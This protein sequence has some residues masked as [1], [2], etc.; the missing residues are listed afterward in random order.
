MK[1]IP[2]GMSFFY[3]VLHSSDAEKFSIK[4]EFINGTN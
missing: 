1:D 4:I 2:N 3:C